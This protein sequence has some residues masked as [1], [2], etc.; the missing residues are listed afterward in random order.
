V[1]TP[2][3]RHHGSHAKSV[4]ESYAGDLF[5]SRRIAKDRGHCIVVTIAPYADDDERAFLPVIIVT[6]DYR[7]A[8]ALRAVHVGSML[9]GFSA[10]PAQMRNHSAKI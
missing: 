4:S 7:P 6:L 2:R 9:A 8:P 5:R 3:R 1:I 10:V